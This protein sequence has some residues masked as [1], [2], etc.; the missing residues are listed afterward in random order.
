MSFKDI[1]AEIETKF[2]TDWAAGAYAAVEVFHEN[3]PHKPGAKDAYV[4]IMVTFGS[5]RRRD[6]GTG[7]SDRSVSVSGAVVVECYTAEDEGWGEGLDYADAVAD[8]FRAHCGE[9]VL[10]RHPSVTKRGNVA[11]RNRV[12]VAVPFTAYF[13]K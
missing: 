8:I 1:Q 5:E 6:I 7:T 11:N 3:T 13:Y 2:L 10:L 4:K 12:D 9:H